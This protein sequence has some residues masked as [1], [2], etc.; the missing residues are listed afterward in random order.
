LATPKLFFALFPCM[1]REV[2]IKHLIGYYYMH[3]HISVRFYQVKE[4]VLLKEAK[5]KE[6]M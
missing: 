6:E 3:A 5:E 2:Q 1:G 4:K